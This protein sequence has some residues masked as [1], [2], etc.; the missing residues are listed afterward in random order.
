LVGSKI[1]DKLNSK[2]NTKREIYIKRVTPGVGGLG[3]GNAM[4]QLISDGTRDS[5]EFRASL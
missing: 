1:T 3:T 5:F 4:S 2:N